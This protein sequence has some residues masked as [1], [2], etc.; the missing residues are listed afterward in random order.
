L[1]IAGLVNFIQW[2]APYLARHEKGATEW[3]AS[4]SRDIGQRLT[5]FDYYPYSVPFAT[6]GKMR[7]IGL[8]E[9][10]YLAHPKLSK[11]L[12]ERAGQEEVLW[13]TAYSNPGLEDGVEFQSLGHQTVSFDRIVSKTALPA[14]CRKYVIDVDILKGTHITNSTGLAVRKI[15]DDGPLA[16]RGHWG[17]GSQ[18]QSKNSL[19][20]ARWSREGAGI[21]GPVPQVGRAVRITIEAAAS[22]DDGLPGQILKITP[23]W[24]GTSLALT[25]SNDLTR[26][27][28]ILARPDGSPDGSPTGIYKIFSEM[29]YDPGKI[30]ISGYPS[31]LGARIHLIVIE[32]MESHL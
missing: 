27:S 26:V 13:V 29:P 4:L 21:I 19:L 22:R 24:T 2:P 23:P 32:E 15:L 8:S 18:I 14:E 20:P 17:R 3:V 6:S 9:Y 1:L 28:G 25:I 30:G 31:D 12:V 11:W 10:G 16:L 5:F 7:V